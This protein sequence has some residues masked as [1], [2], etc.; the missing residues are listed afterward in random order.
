MARDP[1]YKKGDTFSGWHLAE[2]LGVGGNG[3]V[4][5]ATR[6]ESTVALKILAGN[7]TDSEPY[8]RFVTEVTVLRQLGRRPGILPLLDFNLPTAPSKADPSWLSMPIAVPLRSALPRDAPL[9]SAVRAIQSISATLAGL[10]AERS[11]MHRDIKPENLYLYDR[12]WCV[13]DFGL[14]ADP[15]GEPVTEVGHVLGARFYVAPELHRSG[16]LSWDSADLYALAKTL[17][18]LITGQSYPPPG[19]LVRA[20]DYFQLSTY[21]QANEAV[22]Q[23]ERLI[24]RAT[25]PEPKN[26]PTMPQ[27]SEEL[28]LW[29]DPPEI[30]TPVA[31]TDTVRERI[32]T[33]VVSSREVESRGHQLREYVDNQVVRL[34][35][36]IQKLGALVK[37]LTD[38]EPK[39]GPFPEIESDI[40]LSQL[41]HL[42]DTYYVATIGCRITA[43]MRRRSGFVNHVAGLA[44]CMTTSGT[45]HLLAMH[46]LLAS[47][48]ARVLHV[49][50][51]NTS[52]PMDSLLE[53]QALSQI[54]T[55]LQEKAPEALELFA[56]RHLLSDG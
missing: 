56:H 40:H 22:R 35:P 49:R 46:V 29:L 44:L 55:G 18:V 11:L 3:E 23:L 27:F 14:V 13:G 48:N 41:R 17:W 8:K 53:D 15:D 51:Q 38:L 45:L 21:I 5:R 42:Q 12:Q 33:A 32:R 25:D 19:H 2:L 36:D 37:S 16:A 50:V 10:A 34:Q 24:E 39:Y 4:W 1:R 47:P 9:L 6:G 7:R 28:K 31:P 52:V 54:F 26:R 43:P 30:P 20:V